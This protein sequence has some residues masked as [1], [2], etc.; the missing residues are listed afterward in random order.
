MADISEESPSKEVAEILPTFDDF[1][2]NSSYVEVLVL[3][4]KILQSILHKHLRQLV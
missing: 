3:L 2:G 4:E 1:L